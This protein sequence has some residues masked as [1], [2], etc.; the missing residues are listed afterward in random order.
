MVG[1]GCI[2]DNLPSTDGSRLYHPKKKQVSA[3][4]GASCLEAP[5]DARLR[6]N[7]DLPVFRANAMDDSPSDLIS[8]APSSS[9]VTE[10]CHQEEARMEEDPLP[11]DKPA[12]PSAPAELLTLMPAPVCQPSSGARPKSGV[13]LD[14]S[15]SCNPP[16]LSDRQQ[17]DASGERSRKRTS[18]ARTPQ[19]TPSPGRRV[20]QPSGD[21]VFT[22]TLGQK[23]YNTATAKVPNGDHA[24]C[25]RATE[26][27][28]A[29]SQVSSGETN[30]G[31][32]TWQEI[33]SVVVSVHGRAGPET[34]RLPTFP[35][36]VGTSRCDPCRGGTNVAE[37]PL[38]GACCVWTYHVTSGSG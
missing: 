7:P 25:E 9:K 14:P 30:H 36:D 23:V 11:L 24:S 35:M 21:A 16:A 12:E 22:I 10:T 33:P 2:D 19:T 27:G 18:S 38:V 34:R 31:A 3:S 6:L 26:G 17:L 37:P 28:P 5:T 1:R 15:A 32:Q 8:G 20:V 29:C 4:T 13:V